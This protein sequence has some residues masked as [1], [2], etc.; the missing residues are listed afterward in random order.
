MILGSQWYLLFNIIAG[1]SLIPKDLYHVADN[2]SLKGWARWRRFI[3]PAVLPYAVTGSLAA[4]G[5]AWNASIIAEYVKW[6]NTDIIATGLG[7]YILQTTQMGD[8]PRVALGTGV[9]CLY[10]LLLNRFV[11]Y[12]LYKLSERHAEM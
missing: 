11:W 2:L 6:G 1:A 12:P 3:I 7:A 4:A 5:G 8:F 10:V 9:M